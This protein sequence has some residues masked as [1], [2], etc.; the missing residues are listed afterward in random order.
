MIITCE[1]CNARYLLASLLLGTSGR[2]VRCGVCGH[3]WFQDLVE[4]QYSRQSADD[5]TVADIMQAASNAEPIPDSVRPM[6]EG[7]NVP[8]MRGAKAALVGN[9]IT[10]A[11]MVAVVLCVLVA[12][13]IFTLRA[14]AVQAW[15]PL[16]RAFD[17][18]RI[19]VPIPGDGLIFDGM[20]AGMSLD[21][22]GHENL[23]LS[24]NII[25]LKA[26]EA[27]LPVLRARSADK[28]QVQKEW[29]IPINKDTIGPEETLPFTFT[30][31][32]FSDD[33]VPDAVREINVRFTLK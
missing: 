27:R 29:V 14:S 23:I 15:P 4:E 13:G 25:N 9:N 28:D 11:V 2:K 10:G 6:P 16:M 32:D 7:S 18:A 1:Q 8:A 24:G 12:G 21:A 26:K 30:I 22:D 17:L 20:T 31:K 5:A 33:A 19:S 3:E